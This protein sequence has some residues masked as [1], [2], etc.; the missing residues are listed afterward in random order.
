[1]IEAHLMY[2]PFGGS[3]YTGLRP[4][5]IEALPWDK[6]LWHARELGRRR[7]AE[8]DAVRNATGNGTPPIPQE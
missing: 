1:M 6:L 8:A 5:D 7:A 2:L 3:G 4:Q